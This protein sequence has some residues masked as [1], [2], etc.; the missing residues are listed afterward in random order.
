ML[1]GLQRIVPRGVTAVEE[2]LEE[3]SYTL[4]FSFIYAKKTAAETK[5]NGGSFVHE[6][7]TTCIYIC[8]PFPLFLPDLCEKGIVSM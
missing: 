3:K 4:S 5:C 7:P 2:V 1:I 6:P 8:L